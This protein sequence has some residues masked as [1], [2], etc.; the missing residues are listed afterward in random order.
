MIG[1]KSWGGLVPPVLTAV[2]VG[3][4]VLPAGASASAPPP[5]STASCY[6]SVSPAPSTDEPNLANYKFHCDQGISAYTV[7][8][9]RGGRWNTVDDLSPTASVV[10]LTGEVDSNFIWSCEGTIPGLGVNCNAGTDTIVPGWRWAEGSFDTT[11][12]YCK[13]LPT[14]AKPG[15]LAEPR[16]VTQ[17]VVTNASGA[18]DG[19]FRLPYTGTCLKVPNK[20]PAATTKSK[21]KKKTHRKKTTRR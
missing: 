20:A 3:A 2:T 6:G 16:A 8:V 19:P 7:L 10:K 12:P 4:L 18:E 1:R 15:T 5:E 21:H 17:V 9:N 13:N 14:D 11:D